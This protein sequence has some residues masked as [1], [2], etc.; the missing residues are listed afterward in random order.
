MVSR[1]PSSLPACLRSTLLFLLVAG[2]AGISC[3]RDKLV[4]SSMGARPAWVYGIEPEAVIVSAEGRT[5]DEARDKAFTAVKESIVNSVA[6]NVRSTVEIEVSEKVMNDVRIFS[7]NT[8]MNTTITGTFLNSLRGIHIN[9][10]SDW[11]WEL[12]RNRDR[13]RYVVYHV[14]YPFTEKELAAYIREWEALDETLNQELRNLDA[15]AE[16]SENISELVRLQTEAERLAQV[17]KEP[18]RSMALNTASR[19]RGRL[20]DA[21]LEAT[22]HERGDLTVALR[23][24]GS[25]LRLPGPVGFTSPCARLENQHFSE[26]DRQ[27]YIRYDAALCNADHGAIT[28]KARIGEREISLNTS[29]PEDPDHVRLRISGP[30]RLQRL[31]GHLHEWQ[32]PLRLL[33]ADSVEVAEIEVSLERSTG[34]LLAALSRKGREGIYTHIRQPLDVSLNGSGDHFI[35]F[36]ADRITNEAD[37]I[38]T[39]VFENTAV[40]TASGSLR[41]KKRGTDSF[42]TYRFDGLGVVL[43]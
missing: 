21:A 20:D 43:R 29:V 6:V 27:Y 18:R 12:R 41:Y 7:E 38:F 5:H 28:L 22:A 8:Q 31:N 16:L 42:R 17:F 30:L 37:D 9:R 33:S 23:S 39:S 3:K 25:L 19:I 32:L 4:E 15:R 34:R 36:H 35:K 13:E 24:N 40:Y 2:M 11:Y 10:A 1:S 26:D 14:K